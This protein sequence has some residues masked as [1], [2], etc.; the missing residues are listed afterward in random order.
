MFISAL[1]GYFITLSAINSRFT[2]LLTYLLT[3]QGVKH[4]CNC[5]ST[6]QMFFFL[7]YTQPR[8]G[9]NVDVNRRS[10]SRRWFRCEASH[11][12]TYVEALRDAF[13]NGVRPTFN[14]ITAAAVNANRIKDSYSYSPLS[15]YIHQP[16]TTGE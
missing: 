2:Y 10:E 12:L 11:T 1:E 15:A 13:T 16:C 6:L 3:F 14:R 7:F 8:I 5:F 9:T 4:F